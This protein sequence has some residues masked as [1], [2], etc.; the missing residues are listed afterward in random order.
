MATGQGAKSVREAVGVFQS[1]DALQDAIDDL[2]SSG[3]DRAE[4]SLAASERAIEEK[5]GH[6]YRKV[7]ELEDDA[8]VPRVSY[9]APESIGNAQGALV[10]GLMY[11]GA[12]ATSGAIV[13]SGGAL[14]AA[15]AAAV[16]AGGAGAL[17]GAVLAKWI[18]DRHARHLQQ[19][20]DH[21]G[22]LLWVRAWNTER[23]ARAVEILKAH[24]GQDVHIHELPAAG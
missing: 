13:L 24:S 18:G 21:G 14:A 19:Q 6:V 16:A 8:A 11:V 10:G 7:S 9:V 1:A 2:E 5:L 22:L 3:F 12:V 15:I 17:I 20:L 23:E 4:L